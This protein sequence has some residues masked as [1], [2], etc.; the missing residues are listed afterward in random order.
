M[1]QKGH[2]F[3][4]E[5]RRNKERQEASFFFDFWFLF[6]QGKRK[7]KKKEVLNSNFK[8]IIERETITINNYCPPK[9]T[10]ILFSVAIL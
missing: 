7:R 4:L 3:C 8:R 2:V 1:A 9:W 5:F 10:V 6:H